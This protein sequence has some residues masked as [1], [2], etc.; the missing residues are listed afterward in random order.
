MGFED[1]VLGYLAELSQKMTEMD[2]R[3][4]TKISNIDGRLI[5]VEQTVIRIENN[6][7]EKLA[8]LFDGYELLRE[9]QERLTTVVNQNTQAI[10]EL[11]NEV[12]ILGRKVDEHEITLKVIK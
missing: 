1:K 4:S 7:G 10:L 12:K 3:L 6:H 11:S 8:A 5:N 2:N 9:S